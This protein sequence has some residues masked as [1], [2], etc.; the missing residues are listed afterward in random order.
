MV[1][2]RAEAEED[3]L[4][5]VMPVLNHCPGIGEQRVVGMH[6]ALGRARRAR[7]KGEIDDLVRVCVDGRQGTEG[8]QLSRV[9]LVP[10]AY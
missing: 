6:D 9:F 1:A 10:E 8:Q 3:G 5:V 2:K 7:G 4:R